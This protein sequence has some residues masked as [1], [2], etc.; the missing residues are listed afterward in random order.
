MIGCW[1]GSRPPYSEPRCP[2]SWRTWTRRYW[3]WRAPRARVPWASTTPI[4]A[5]R[6]PSGVTAS[7]PSRRPPGSPLPRDA[8]DWACFHT[9]A[10]PLDD[11]A[12]LLRVPPGV[13]LAG[14]SGALQPRPPGVRADQPRAPLPWPPVNASHRR[15][16]YRIS[17]LTRQLALEQEGQSLQH[18]AGTYAAQVLIGDSV[19]L[20][21]RDPALSIRNSPRRCAC[22]SLVSLIMR[23]AMIR[24]ISPMPSR[25]DVWSS[26][27]GSDVSSRAKPY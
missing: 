16:A 24:R 3:R 7:R 14:G 18:Y 21:V 20:S 10:T 23:V 9:L 25:V 17:E 4:A 15:G 5:W 12:T 8:A 19:L 27:A 22:N 11:L 2:S 13:R 1:R 6:P 26:Y